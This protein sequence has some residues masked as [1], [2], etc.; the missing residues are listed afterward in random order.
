MRQVTLVE[1][2]EATY[3]ELGTILQKLKTERIVSPLALEIKQRTLPRHGRRGAA[4]RERPA[5]AVDGGVEVD[6]AEGEGTTVELRVPL[7]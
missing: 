5:V 3:R 7:S 6:S 4:K 2:D 1:N